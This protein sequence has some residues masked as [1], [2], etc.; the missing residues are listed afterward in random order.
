[1]EKKEIT[2]LNQAM[3][4]LDP[5]H[6]TQWVMTGHS[7]VEADRENRDG[8]FFECEH[9]QLVYIPS[10]IRVKQL[11]V[12]TSKTIKSFPQSVSTSFS[13]SLESLRTTCVIQPFNGSRHSIAAYTLPWRIT[14]RSQPSPH[15]FLHLLFFTTLN[16]TYFSDLST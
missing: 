9:S 5:P 15:F 12:K 6:T 13:S 14:L 16:H 4:F 2:K 10:G 11:G 7:C 1:M 3:N 8:A